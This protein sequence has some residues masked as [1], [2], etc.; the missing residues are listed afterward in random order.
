ML[1]AM[2]LADVEGCAALMLEMAGLGALDGPTP[3]VQLHQ[4]FFGRAPR[5]CALPTEAK[6]DE[7]DEGP[8]V[9]LRRGLSPAR[10]RWLL[11]HELGE[12]WMRENGYEREDIEQRADALGAALA[13]PRAAF[14]SAVKHHGHRVHTLSRLFATTQSL[15]L[16]RVGETTGRPVALLRPSGTIARGD[17][18]E[19]P[20]TSTLVRALREGRSAV[21]PLRID[22]EPHRW[23]LMARR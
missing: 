11:G 6:L 14:R 16:L 8:I 3:M 21:H 10:A 18:Y 13:V 15:A 17:A 23:G 12:F 2:D 22:D 1:A 5:W 4:F 7:D 9:L 19:W 20:R